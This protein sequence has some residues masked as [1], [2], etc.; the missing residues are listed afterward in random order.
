MQGVVSGK[1]SV[2][3]QDGRAAMMRALGT[4]RPGSGP[5][6]YPFSP[7]MVS[8]LK[9]WLDAGVPASL[10]QD[11]ARTTRVTADADPVGAWD[12]L[13]GNGNNVIQATAGSRP[14][15]KQNIQG[16]KPII[17]FDA[18][19]DF[20]GGD[21]SDFTPT[22]IY[23]VVQTASSALGRVVDGGSGNDGILVQSSLYAARFGSASNRTIADVGAAF[24]VLGAVSGAPALTIYDGVETST[25]NTEAFASFSVFK[26]GAFSAG[27]QPFAGDIAAL[28]IYTGTQTAYQRAA[29]SAYLKQ[30]WG[31]P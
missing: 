26:V 7:E 17:R 30:R 22:T 13:S 18:V 1:V 20:L 6:D 29:I 21:P 24:H 27:T 4:L 9:L 19:D 31:T 28:L 14:T 11:S 16:G 8:G 3:G 15:F 10:W 2:S 25:G 23:A 5:A 12:D